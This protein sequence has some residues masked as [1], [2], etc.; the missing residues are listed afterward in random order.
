MVDQSQ[1]L[2]LAV[3]ANPAG[4]LVLGNGFVWDYPA[5]V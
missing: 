1:T 2:G 5:A 3:T 4:Q